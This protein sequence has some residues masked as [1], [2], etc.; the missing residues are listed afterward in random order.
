MAESKSR[1]WSTK[2][3]ARE[4]LRFLNGTTLTDESTVAALMDELKSQ[5]VADEVGVDFTWGP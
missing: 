2:T 3:L 4:L 1:N 5:I